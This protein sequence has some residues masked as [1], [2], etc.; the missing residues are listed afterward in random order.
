MGCDTRY[1]LLVQKTVLLN[2]ERKKTKSWSVM[3]RRVQCSEEAHQ[4]GPALSVCHTR[5]NERQVKQA[6]KK[7]KKKKKK[8]TIRMK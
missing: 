7:K 1:A 3:Q 2:N 8:G 6:S 4:R 5:K